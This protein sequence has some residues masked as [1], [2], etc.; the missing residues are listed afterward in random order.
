MSVNLLRVH[1]NRDQKRWATLSLTKPDADEE[2]YDPDQPPLPIVAARYLLARCPPYA[3]M[4]IKGSMSLSDAY[5]RAVEDA[6]R[7]AFPCL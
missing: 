1:L 3:E 5:D 4:V 6:W 2:A 7:A